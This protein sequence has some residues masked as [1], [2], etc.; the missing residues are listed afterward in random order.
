ML[1]PAD[2]QLSVSSSRLPTSHSAALSASV[3]PLNLSPAAVSHLL[4]IATAL[5]AA[6]SSP[7]TDCNVSLPEQPS[8]TDSNKDMS[9]LSEDE[10]QHLKNDQAAASQPSTDDLR[11]GMFSMAPVLASRPGDVASAC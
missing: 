1:M 4:A 8:F 3:L 6:A 10:Q 2:L 11:C 5:K 7:R 9:V